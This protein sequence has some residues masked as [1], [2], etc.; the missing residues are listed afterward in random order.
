MTKYIFDVDGTLTPSRKL[1]N[2]KFLE[3]MLEFCSENECYIVTGS[4]R[5]KTVEQ[6]TPKLYNSM[7]RVYQCSGSD[8]W[9]GN[10]HKTTLDFDMTDKLEQFLNYWL[11]ASQFKHRTGNHFDM[12]PGMVNFSVVGRNAEH[13]QRKEY[14]FWDE[15]V[16]ER[17]RIADA[18]NENFEEYEAAVAGETGVDIYYKGNNKSQILRDFDDVDKIVFFGDKIEEGGND[19]EIA[20]VVL[21][22]DGVAIPV[23]NWRETWAML[24]NVKELV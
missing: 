14:F 21:E 12:R 6:I 10:T 24:K 5:L 3:Y 7:K 18:I 4:D 9:E 17:K 22:N 16:H 20:T 15:S 8:V 1:I 2:D 11:K 23:S 19:F 13:N